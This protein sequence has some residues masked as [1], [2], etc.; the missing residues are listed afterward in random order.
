MANVNEKKPETLER[1]WFVFSGRRLLLTDKMEIPT[2]EHA[3]IREFSFVRQLQLDFTNSSHYTA[4]IISDDLLPD[5]A[6]LKDLK[7]LYHL[8]PPNII[9][10]AGKAYQLIEWDKSHQFCGE[11]GSQTQIS[12]IEHS[13]ICIN[14]SCK[15]IFY[16]RISPVVIVAVERNQEI[17]LARSPHF[18]AGIYSIL[19]GFVELGETIE[20]AV[21]REVYEETAIKIQ[22]LRYFSSQPWPFPNSLMLGFQADY[23]SGNVVCAPN[24]IEDAA[25]FHVNKLPKTFPGNVTISQRLINDFR[26]RHGQQTA[27]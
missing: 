25:F 2:D 14:P 18:P 5:D 21:H 20:Q 17:L 15:R 13:R 6:Q 4:E 7:E 26:K 23:K 8:L 19:A 12:N 9:T 11:C 22:N 24:E 27:F 16:P 1:L 10:L 3:L